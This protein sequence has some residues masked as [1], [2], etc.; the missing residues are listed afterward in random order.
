MIVDEIPQ[1]SEPDEECNVYS[2]EIRLLK[3]SIKAE[4]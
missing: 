3:T 1:A 2:V 4:S